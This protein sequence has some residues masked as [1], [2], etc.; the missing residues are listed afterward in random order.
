[1][2]TIE[3]V[4]YLYYL[5]I[6]ILSTQIFSMLVYTSFDVGEVFFNNGN[7]N[8]LSLCVH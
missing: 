6:D 1:M 5:Y 3:T 7:S 2:L 8:T 4:I